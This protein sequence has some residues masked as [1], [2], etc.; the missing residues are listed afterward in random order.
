MDMNTSKLMVISLYLKDM[1]FIF[2]EIDTILGY[3]F[4]HNWNYA[5]T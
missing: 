5:Y 1:Y 2:F 4:M 3:A